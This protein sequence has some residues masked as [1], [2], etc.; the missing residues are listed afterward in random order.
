MGGPRNPGPE[1]PPHLTGLND[2]KSQYW[3][4][5]DFSFQELAD[6]F[7]PFM[8]SYNDFLLQ[9]Q[10]KIGPVLGWALLS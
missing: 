2:N 6:I 10:V 5:L 4:L 7:Q 8:Y 9:G 1:D 3:A